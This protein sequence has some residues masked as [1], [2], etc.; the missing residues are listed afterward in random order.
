MHACQGAVLYQLCALY[1][2]YLL[3]YHVAP[4]SGGHSGHLCMKT[5][6]VQTSIFTADKAVAHPTFTADFNDLMF[7]RALFHFA[8][9]ELLSVWQTVGL[10]VKYCFYYSNRVSGNGES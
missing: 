3:L 7:V 6:S 8:I 4:T 2:C 5:S 1:G 10:A 9:G